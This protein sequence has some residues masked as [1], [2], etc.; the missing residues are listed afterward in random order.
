MPARP[1]LN[2]AYFLLGTLVAAYVGI[3]LCR[4]N[5]AVAVPL[6]Q[7][8]W[9]LTKAQVGL[10]GSV[11]TIAYAAGK[12]LFGPMT[13]RVGGRVSLLC[14]MLL[15]AL[16]GAA[17]A[18]APGLGALGVIYS[19][20]R[21]CGAAAWGA[22]IKQTSQ[23]F[24]P[25]RLPFACGLLSLSFVIGG[26]AA[27][28]FAGLIAQATHDSWRAVLAAP[29]LVLALLAATC[30]IVLPR[31]ARMASSADSVSARS[32]DSAPG[33]DNP[34]PE[35]VTARPPDFRYGQVL[36]LFG[37]RKFLV[38]LG[39]SFTL[40]LLRETFN[41][42]TVDLMRTEGSR[43][44]T[45]LAAFLSAPF[46]LCGA[47]GIIFM[48]WSF[49]RLR[50]GGR[51]RLLVAML[52]LLTVLLVALPELFSRRIWV[53]PAGIGLIG[54][55]VCGPYS[56]LAGVLSVEVRGEPFAATVSGLVDAVGYV[57]GI[58][59]GAGFGWLLMAGGYRLGFQVMGALTLV[60]A[61]LSCFLYRTPSRRPVEPTARLAAA[62]PSPG[63]PPCP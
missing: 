42:W 55:L 60:S 30:W 25:E 3:Y 41:F 6:L 32:N 14:S 57:A 59:A 56:L 48:G 50:P 28:P 29:S 33:V 21:L 7:E 22:M 17:G 10:I 46:D 54:F 49:G 39:L 9:G 47:A 5:F 23:W 31:R 61:V 11:S 1:E 37:E 63:N 12:V 58:F 35:T 51:Q 44:S 38:V 4:K 18:F 13:D 34:K 45:A 24:A 19:A 36:G 2:R 27:V 20:N 62:K 8:S 43:A 16:F 15:V 26:A 53:L 52:G 40:T